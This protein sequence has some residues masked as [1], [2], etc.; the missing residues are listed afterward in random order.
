MKVLFV[1]VVLTIVSLRCADS[2][3]CSVDQFTHFN[4]SDPYVACVEDPCT[5]DSIAVPLANCAATAHC[6]LHN[7]KCY[8]KQSTTDQFTVFSAL[9]EVIQSLSNDSSPV[10]NDTMERFFPIGA[11]TIGGIGGLPTGGISTPIT[12]FPSC[13]PSPGPSGLPGLGGLP[14]GLQ[15]LSVMPGG[16]LPPGIFPGLGYPGSNSFPGGSAGG[17][18]GLYPTMCPSAFPTTCGLNAQSPNLL[19]LMDPPLN[20]PYCLRIPCSTSNPCLEKN[21]F[22][23]I[24]VPGCYFDIGL[25]N[26]R[27]RYG[28]SVMPGVPVCHL[29]IRNR[30]F[31]HLANNH[32]QTSGRPW[33]GIYTQCFISENRNEIYSPSP[34]CYQ[35]NALQYIG[36]N[37][38]VAGWPGITVNECYLMDGCP[39]NGNCYRPGQLTRVQVRSGK[40]T[41]RQSVQTGYNYFGQPMC[42][43][44]NPTTPQE[45]LDGYHQCRQ[46]GCVVDPSITPTVLKQQ[47]YQIATTLPITQQLPFWNGVLSGQIRADNYRQFMRPSACPTAQASPGTVPYSLSLGRKKRSI[48]PGAGSPSNGGFPNFVPQCPYQSYQGILTGSFVGCCQRN[49]CYTPRTSILRSASG[50][51][52]YQAEWGEY[53][54]CTAS[55]GGGTRK[56][57]RP[58]V[59]YHNNDTCEHEAQQTHRCNVEACPQYGDW[60]NYGV[61][62]H[63]CGGGTQTRTRPCLPEGSTCQD[64]AQGGASQSRPCNQIA[65]P[66]YSAWDPWGDCSVRC[67]VGEKTRTRTCTSPPGAAPCSPASL[68]STESCAVSCGTCQETEGA[69]QPYNKCYKEITTQCVPDAQG[70]AYCPNCPNRI[71]KRRCV[72]TNGGILGSYCAYCRDPQVPCLPVSP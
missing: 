48:F 7:G 24:S 43:N 30:K 31:H 23:C 69:C 19:Q 9:L 10:T 21:K 5:E 1:S 65:C 61:C 6:K 71:I 3:S 52:A 27:Q 28:N 38:Q 4:A 12:G 2:Q 55:C 56:R 13:N 16:M 44:Y 32:V 29:A 42:L 54:A 37:P 49:Y 35:I 36:A 53:S 70:G 45:Y 18:P 67:G 63:A 34:G 25:A 11:Y 58:C 66:T 47:L 64:D 40:D 39:V 72:P 41:A 57:S 14:S 26:L 20:I 17:L 46:A 8:A 59:K 50:V 60:G 68:I 22:S 51:A 15:G 33:N 62:S